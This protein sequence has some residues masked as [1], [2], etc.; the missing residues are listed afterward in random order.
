[1]EKNSTVARR[2]TKYPVLA[3]VICGTTTLAF[4][5][6]S[7]RAYRAL[8]QADLAQNGLNR[9]EGA[10]FTSP[11][12][13][14]VDVRGGQARLYVA[15]KG[16]H[17]VL[18]WAN[19][20]AYQTGEAPALILGQFSPSG[21][22]ALGI[23]AAG[24]TSPGGMAVDPGTGN[25]YVA[26]TGN[27]RVLR[28]TDPFA[29]PSRV[30][31]DAVFGQADFNGHSAN[32]SGNSRNSLRSPSAVAIDASGNLWIADTGNHRVLRYPAGVLNSAAPA[33]DLVIGQRDFETTGQNRT[34]T[35]VSTA[36]LDSPAG[37]AFDNEGALY[38]SDSGN[39]RVLRFVAPFG[40][41]SA[42]V[43]VYSISSFSTAASAPAGLTVSDRNL[44]VAVPGEHRVVMF[45]LN[46]SGP[47]SPVSV[48]GQADLNSHEQNTGVHPR[49]A[50]YTLNAPG[51]VKADQS[52]NLYVADSGNHRVLRFAANV[53]SA[54]RVWGQT[55][56]TSNAPNQVKAAGLGEVS[57][58]AIDYSRSPS[59]LYASD[60]S[61]HRILIW[62]DAARF[63]TGDVADG[64]IGQR[65]LRSA[66][67]NQG[68]SGRR[69]TPG[70]LFSP[71]GIAVDAAG[72]L[73]VCDT[74][75]H[76]VL[77]FPSPVDQPAGSVAADTAL[78]QPDL[79]TG[80]GGATGAASLRSPSGVAISP[81]GGVFVAD[82]GNNRVLEFSPGSGTGS[83]AVRVYGQPHFL[84][85]AGPRSVSSQ[86]LS[87]PAGVAVDAAFNL[88]VADTDAN[89]VVIYTNT[90][91]AVTSSNSAAMV[92]G[93]DAFE[94]SV[95]GA[96]R[97]RLQ[98]PTDVA[99]DSAGRIYVADSRNHRVLVFPSLIFLPVAD[100]AASG[101][102]GQADFG[103]VAPNWNSRD[104]LATAESLNG[105]AG[106][107][108][109]RRDTL[110]VADSGNHRVMHFL[111]AAR[112]VH[113]A[114]A[115]ASAVAPGSL[116]SIEGEGLADSEATAEM[117][118]GLALAG[119]EVV[120]NDDLRAPLL[121]VG[122]SRISVQIPSSAPSG[123]QRIAV[124]DAETAELVAGSAVSV[125][126]YA[127]G[128]FTKVLNGDN[129]ANSESNPA[130]RGSTIKIFGTGQGPVRP[131]LPDG[132][133]ASG[134]G[135]LTVAVPT[136]DSNTCLTRQPSVC[137]AMGSVFGDVRFSGLASGVVGTWQLDVRIPDNAT[138]G[139][140]PVRVVINGV[141]S[142]IISVA[143][144]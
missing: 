46:G 44:H 70:S 122:F 113:G 10:E 29:N 108:V 111:K 49:A 79:F 33:A 138:P 41:E 22:S 142:N 98:A 18:G 91:D 82:T 4:G 39:R 48:L 43:A 81:D 58:I 80:A 42:A 134:S 94:R 117:P 11:S 63:R 36:G 37:L 16:N 59:P 143:I 55:D 132:E 31:S 89:R 13:V 61:N 109:D 120:V 141:P 106:I 50:A 93:S 74:G 130:L 101:V 57:K 99:L 32:G 27:H 17:R 77:R 51:D 119:R 19:A 124:R 3:A 92:I 114:Y 78:G 107:F 126:T 100:A 52:G 7:S 144:R 131:S 75:N 34:S 28:F 85:S 116:M 127:P 112:M 6:I 105:P 76:R 104:G 103:A 24:F 125:A 71:R 140:V 30:E 135:I 86:T 64:V 133:P 8:G 26:D 5:Q 83:A 25:L 9:I 115:Q 47:A 110:Y 102:I 53:R 69:I 96:G 139:V 67:P 95:T 56:F 136:A 123:Q 128:L 2:W 66:V 54:D 90:R 14:A 129:T 118:L 1:M 40:I 73:Y 15:D 68:G 97:Q 23:G 121:S 35:T 137:V 87:Q 20:A 65:D 21:A 12:A 45:A 72:N 88:Y 62:K 84:S 38:V 60:T